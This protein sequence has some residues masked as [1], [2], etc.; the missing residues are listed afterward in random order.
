MERLIH[1]NMGVL[2]KFCCNI[3]DRPVCI[4]ERMEFNLWCEVQPKHYLY[5]ITP[6]RMLPEYVRQVTDL[7]CA[8][9]CWEVNTKLN[10]G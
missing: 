2:F 6:A 1:F 9:V 4:V 8:G 3:V 7:L 5:P 10:R